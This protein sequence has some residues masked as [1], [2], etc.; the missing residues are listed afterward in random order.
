MTMIYIRKIK[1]WVPGNPHAVSVFSV[2][3]FITTFMVYALLN[4]ELFYS[5]FSRILFILSQEYFLEFIKKPGGLLEYAGNLITQTYYSG[6]SGAFVLSIFT[7]L[8]IFI[9]SGIRRWFPKR[10]CLPLILAPS[11]ILFLS[12]LSYAHFAHYSLGYIIS[13][14]FFLFSVSE[15]IKKRGLLILATVPA[16]FLL[17][18]SFALVY[19]GML[20]VYFLVMKNG[21]SRWI[22]SLLILI[23]IFVLYFVFYRIVYI[24]PFSLVVLSP[25]IENELPFPLIILACYTIM[26][27]LIFKYS[28]P[29]GEYS[30]KLPSVILL[31]ALAYGLVTVALNSDQTKMTR[32]ERWIAAGNWDAIIDQH[33]KSP[34]AG[35]TGEYYYNLAL[36]NRG[37]LCERLFVTARSYGNESLILTRK[38]ENLEKAVYF[39]YSAGLINEAH[40]LA[41]EAMVNYGYTPEILKYLIKTNLIQGN[42]RIAEKNIKILSKTFHF[43]SEA[44][45]YKKFLDDHSKIKSDSELGEK[46]KLLPKV[47][48]FIRNDDNQNLELFLKSNPVNRI[49]LEYKIA[50]LLLNRDLETLI[51]EVKKLKDASFES[52]PVHIEEAILMYIKLNGALPDTDFP[53]VRSETRMRF[54]QYTKDADDIKTD[55][56]LR[57]KW[58]K[59][60]WYY[61]DLE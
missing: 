23:Y 46:L 10:S 57:D 27:P 34:A 1:S 43:K 15:S 17:T 48:F 31:T 42:Y 13:I 53:E 50:A 32:M 41:Y 9:F 61:Y 14:S 56:L 58:R 38:K 2:L 3:I 18:G 39:Y 21:K 6:I 22:I 45:E 28:L 30:G 54:I 59:T 20:I 36:A 51:F 40:H 25:L 8:P 7:V 4:T 12:Q 19:T 35:P 29:G 16:A 55:A 60:F 26:F 5:Q 37:L 44:S 52:I 47:D 49:A 24:Q 11:A 33:E